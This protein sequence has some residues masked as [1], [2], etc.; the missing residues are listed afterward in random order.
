MKHKTIK[1]AI[2]GILTAAAM[3]AVSPGAMACHDEPNSQIN[4]AACYGTIDE[5]KRLLESGVYVDERTPTGQTALHQATDNYKLTKLLIAAGADVNAADKKGVTALHFAA[6][7]GNAEIAKVLI[8]AGANVNAVQD[9]GVTALHRAANK[10]NTEVVKILIAEG[11]NVNNAAGASNKLKTALQVAE[12]KGHTQVANILRNADNIRQPQAESNLSKS[13]LDR[14]IA[15]TQAKQ[16]QAAA[17]A[18]RECDALESAMAAAAAGVAGNRA[19]SEVG[20]AIGSSFGGLGGIIGN[21]AKEFTEEAVI[22]ASGC[23]NAKEMLSD[24]NELLGNYNSIKESGSYKP[25]NSSFDSDLG[26]SINTP[27]VEWTPPNHEPNTEQ[28]AKFAEQAKNAEDECDRD[29]LRK[30][31]EL[32]YEIPDTNETSMASCKLVI[33]LEFYKQAYMC[34]LKAGTVT[35]EIT[36]EAIKQAD[37]RIPL[38]QNAYEQTSSDEGKQKCEAAKRKF[39]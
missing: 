3:L 33:S 31:S 29:F 11:A 20:S 26:G 16:Q 15:E 12:E 27:S 8:A 2:F 14:K 10:G 24:L 13:G 32:E 22:D 18:K 23:D 25:D 1:S 19:K 30:M 34:K 6:A 5:V 7:K 36:N 4:L 9:G 21:Q 35:Q 17:L 37:E 39:L 28:A 38:A